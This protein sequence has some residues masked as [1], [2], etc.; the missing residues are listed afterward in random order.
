MGDAGSIPLGFLAGVVGIYG[1][2]TGL[3]PIWLPWLV[4]SPFIM[5]ASVTLLRRLLSGEKVWQAHKSHYYQRLIRMGWGHKKMALIEY[6]LM[7]A[8]GASAIILLGRPDTFVAIILICW[9]VIYLII[10]LVIDSKWKRS[11]THHA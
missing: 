10:G 6:L 7:F 8:C 11:V 4:F 2:H 5:D 1:W 3:W 9:V